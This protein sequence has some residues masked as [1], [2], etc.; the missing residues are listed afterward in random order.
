LAK[1]RFLLGADVPQVV[2]RAK[3]RWEQ[4]AAK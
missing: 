3:Q 1:Q 2:A 4:L